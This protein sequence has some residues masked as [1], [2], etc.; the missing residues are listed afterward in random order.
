METME[1]ETLVIFRKWNNGDV[2]A[3]FPLEPGTNDP[4]TCSSYEHIGQHGAATPHGVVCVTKPALPAEFAA[5]QAELESSPY[6]YRLKVGRRLPSDAVD[7]RR[8][9]LA[10]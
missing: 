1:P 3:L 2:I 8:Q 9:H 6:E 5:L 10:N 4:Y 7:V